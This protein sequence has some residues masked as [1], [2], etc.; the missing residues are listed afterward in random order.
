MYIADRQ[1]HY[2]YTAFSFPVHDVVD[3]CTH[4]E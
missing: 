2:D 4:A 1:G 3:H